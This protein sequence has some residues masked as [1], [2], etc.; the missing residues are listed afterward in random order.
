[1]HHLDMVDGYHGNSV[2]RNCGNRLFYD[3][4]NEMASNTSLQLSGSVEYERDRRGG[5]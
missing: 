1:M 4:P 3:M 5:G 2:S